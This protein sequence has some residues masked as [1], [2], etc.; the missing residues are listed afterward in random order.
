MI[1]SKK[2]KE[3][4]ESYVSLHERA[5]EVLKLANGKDNY[6]SISKNTNLHSTKVSSL[7]TN[8]HQLGL[9]D[10]IKPGVYKKRK[11]IMGYMPKTKA[12]KENIQNKEKELERFGKSV[13]RKKV[14]YVRTSIKLDSQKSKKMM[15]AYGWLYLTENT[16]RE[17]IRKVFSNAGNWWK[18]KVPASIQTS[19]KDAISK[20]KYY[21]PQRNDKLDYTHLGQLMEIIISKNNWNLF[22]PH[23]KESEKNNFKVLFSRVIPFR[24]AIGHCIPLGNEDYKSVEVKFKEILQMVK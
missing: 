22:S 18:V 2:I 3:N 13:N 14:P 15:D 1:D 23:L 20:D 16:F 6:A 17:L 21:S 5:K 12:R 11:G 10:K 8:A 9:A 7:L 4:C 24:N 19:V